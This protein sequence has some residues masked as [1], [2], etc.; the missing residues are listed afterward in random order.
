LRL[1]K[2]YSAIRPAFL[3]SLVY[4]LTT[5]I[6]F[7]GVTYFAFLQTVQKP[8]CDATV[9]LN[10]GTSLLSN[11]IL[12][13]PSEIQPSNLRTFAYPVFLAATIRIARFL[14]LEPIILVTIIQTL[15]YVLAV[16]FVTNK[17]GTN[18]SNTQRNVWIALMLNI[19]IWPYLSST[20]TDSLYVSLFLFFLGICIDVFRTSKSEIDLNRH[21]TF[22]LTL[23]FSTLLV[24]R[25]ASIWIT[26]IFFYF[27]YLNIRKVSPFSELLPIFVGS[28]PIIYQTYI[29]LYLF[30]RLTPFPVIDLGSMQVNWGI[31]YLKY[32]TWLGGGNPQGIYSSKNLIG[33]VS[34]NL[35][36]H[37]YLENPLLG[38]KLIF[39]K[40]IGA[41]DFDFLVP[42]PQNRPW[43]SLLVGIISLLIFLYGTKIMISYLFREKSNLERAVLPRILPLAMFASW[44]AVT[45]VSAVELRFTLPII[46]F[47]ILLIT[48]E[49]VPTKINSRRSLFQILSF[50]ISLIVVILLAQFVRGQTTF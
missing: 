12:V 31:R 45:L 48:H 1:Q 19:F 50:L 13:P 46:T 37:W 25:P 23:C 10:Y 30:G 33:N 32:I 22:F 8:C 17:L 43:Y 6:T 24:L 14:L 20:L 38:I 5:F 18:R 28:A 41:F 39:T 3:S 4:K 34:E 2:I 15:V 36:L 21:K 35:T 47:L 42:Y 16:N 49:G 44:A 9:Y 27:L 40:L 7:V 11:S 26:P 29:N